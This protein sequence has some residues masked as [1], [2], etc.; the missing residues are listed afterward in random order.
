MLPDQS[1]ALAAPGEEHVLQALSDVL[2]RLRL[3]ELV[4]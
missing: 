4:F 1:L 3:E 2:V